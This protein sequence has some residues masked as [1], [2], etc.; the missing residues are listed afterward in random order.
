MSAKV[1]CEDCERKVKPEPVPINHIF[2]LLITLI[3]FGIGFILWA[4]RAM[5]TNDRYRCP[6]CKDDLTSP[7]EKAVK[8]NKEEQKQK[9]KEFDDKHGLPWK[10]RIPVFSTHA[11]IFCLLFFFDTVESPISWYVYFPF[12]VG[13]LSSLFGGGAALMERDLIEERSFVNI[14]TFLLILG[15]YMLIGWL[16]ELLVELL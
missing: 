7:Y 10:M 11:A 1:Y 5:S 12:V 15:A 4:I 6:L 3:S 8:E 2:Y 13:F 14:F 9:D 16:A